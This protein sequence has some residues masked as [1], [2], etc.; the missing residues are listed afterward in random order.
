VVIDS[1][2][3]SDIAA[4][5]GADTIYTDASF[6]ALQGTG[7]PPRRLGA[8]YTNTDYTIV[9]ETDMV[10]TWHIY[11]YAK[12]QAG[13]AFD[14][15]TLIDTRERRRIVGDFT[16]SVLD[17]L[18]G[19]TFPDTICEAYS[20]FDTHGYTVHPVFVLQA[21]DKKGWRTYIPYRA[22][23]PK[24]LD[25]ILVTGL[26]ISAHR[27][28]VP[29]TRMQP[30]IQNQG[31]AA[32]VAA[33]MAAKANGGTRAI[34]IKALQQHLVETGNLK[35]DV[36]D[37][38]D[39]YPLS[40]RQIAEGVDALLDGYKGAA[41][42]LSQPERAL[43]LLRKAYA[44]AKTPEHKLIY[45]H[46]LAVLGDATGLSTLI[47]A[48]EAMPGLDKG[49]RFKAGGQ[50]G[51]N[52]SPLDTLIAAMGR[53]RDRRAVPAIVAKLKLL[54]P[55]DAFSHFRAMAIAVE[56]IGDKAAV[57]PLAALLA[58][59]GI[60]GQAVYAPVE[61]NEPVT[62]RGGGTFG[63]LKPRAVAFREL[64]LARALFRLGDKD[65][66]AK[67]VLEEYAR[68]YRGHLARHAQAVL[69]AGN[70]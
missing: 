46:T 20:N 29:V 48:I 6:I 16:I 52:M 11:L 44:N 10:D 40:E 45:A 70:Q 66:L 33:A 67:T 32:G 54:K 39:S 59:E 56:R 47:A 24:G 63:S 15:G 31:Y 60:R 18:N 49:W 13:S 64:I 35:K 55:K 42:V 36:L 4:A 65:G 26:G 7:L 34:D 3:N 14:L 30:D 58:T 51:R 28:A 38:A 27:D 53:A 61:V 41:A 57:E 8:S 25:G 21:P 5:A 22:L 23:L 68:D 2:G 17:Q 1:T 37:H 50:F 12:R 19:R 62:R 9:D 69:R 43:P